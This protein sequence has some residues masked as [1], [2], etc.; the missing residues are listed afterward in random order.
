M[1]MRRM[2]SISLDQ[3]YYTDEGYLVDHPVVTTCGIFEY[4]N[5]D[6]S[7]RRELRLPEHVFIEKSLKSYKGKPIIITHDA[8][9]VD[10]SNVRRE[11]IGTIMSEGYQDGD[12]VRCE[13][14][15]HDTDALRKCGLKELSLGYSLDTIDEPGE[16]NGEPYDCIQKNIEINLSNDLVNNKK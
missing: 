3:T 5:E 4:Q 15:I 13:I 11:Q 14:I 7:I 9:E 10:K 16:W 12:S 6:G 2:D 1:K 8:G